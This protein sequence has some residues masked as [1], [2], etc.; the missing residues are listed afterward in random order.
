MANSVADWQWLPV[1]HTP[2]A[3]IVWYLNPHNYA[4][5]AYSFRRRHAKIFICNAWVRYDADL[6]FAQKQTLQQGRI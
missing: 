3:G 1:Y 5:N 6:M 4:V 2:I